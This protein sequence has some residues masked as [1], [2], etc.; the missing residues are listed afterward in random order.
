MLKF[1]TRAKFHLGTSHL[2]EMMIALNSSFREDQNRS[3]DHLIRISRSV[4]LNL[5]PH[6]CKLFKST[7]AK[8]RLMEPNGRVSSP[9]TN[10]I[11]R[12]DLTPHLASSSL[13]HSSLSSSDWFVQLLGSL[14]LTRVARRRSFYGIELHN[15][16][17]RI[18][19][20]LTSVD[21]C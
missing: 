13:T 9:T 2:I 18:S 6:M 4:I 3:K 19:N 11:N 20:S 16:N 14:S 21:Q 17:F 15:Q 5:C 10:Y 8:C 12:S 7:S 1:A